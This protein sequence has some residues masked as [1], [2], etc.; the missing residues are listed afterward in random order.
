MANPRQQQR[1]GL[2]LSAVPLPLSLPQ[3]LPVMPGS[4]VHLLGSWDLWCWHGWDSFHSA[5]DQTYSSRISQSLSEIGI[6]HFDS[7]IPTLNGGSEATQ[8]VDGRV[9]LFKND[10][11]GAP[12][13]LNETIIYSI[14][15]SIISL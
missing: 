12:P 4:L 2:Q 9:C 10:K 1:Q 13:T 8:T 11:L 6:L 7:C 5:T 14:A 3:T 15:K